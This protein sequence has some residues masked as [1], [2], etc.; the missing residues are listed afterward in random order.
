MLAGSILLAFGLSVG[1]VVALIAISPI[2]LAKLIKLIWI[3]IALGWMMLRALWV[4][5]DPPEGYRRFRHTSIL[6]LVHARTDDDQCL[7]ILQGKIASELLTKRLRGEP[8]TERQIKLPTSLVLQESTC[9]AV[10]KN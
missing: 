7:P 8:I 1:L 2:L 3:P 5:I 9:P 10:Q 4:R 6:A